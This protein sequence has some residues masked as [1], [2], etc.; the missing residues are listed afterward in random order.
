MPVQRIPQLLLL[1]AGAMASTAWPGYAEDTW[2]P[3]A[4]TTEDQGVFL[5]LL[6][7]VLLLVVL[8]G[9]PIGVGLVTYLCLKRTHPISSIRVGSIL[10]FACLAQWAYF[11]L[12]LFLFHAQHWLLMLVAPI[13]GAT[14]S[15][16]KQRR[17]LVA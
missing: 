12:A 10:F 4:N 11:V 1:I 8:I 15:Y 16:F 7:G 6:A 9:L 17:K 2:N 13:A 3:F 14:G 5:F